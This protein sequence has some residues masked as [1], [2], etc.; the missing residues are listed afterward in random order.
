M[1]PSHSPKLLGWSFTIRCNLLSYPGY[2]LERDSQRILQ[3]QP[4]G[5]FLPEI[6]LDL[7]GIKLLRSLS[8]AIMDD[9]RN[10][11]S[12]NVQLSATSALYVTL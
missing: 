1:G 6:L 2:F 12:K 8:I 10:F 3:P 5:L 9:R 11:K 7:G 4:T